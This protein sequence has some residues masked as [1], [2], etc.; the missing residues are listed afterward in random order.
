VY[1]GVTGGAE[2]LHEVAE[3]IHSG[4]PEDWAKAA[5]AIA[6]SYGMVKG[7]SHTLA[8]KAFQ[9]R[10]EPLE[11]REAMRAEISTK[12]PTTTD[13][14]RIALKHKVPATDV[15]HWSTQPLSEIEMAQR[16]AAD[17][18]ETVR[19]S[20]MDAAK[21]DKRKP[22]KTEQ[23]TLFSLNSKA[24][25]LKEVGDA[26]L[27]TRVKAVDN[28]PAPKGRTGS[29]EWYESLYKH[30]WTKEVAKALEIPKNLLMKESA[31]I[32][33][34]RDVWVAQRNLDTHRMVVD[35]AN[36]VP[37]EDRAVDKLGWVIQDTATPEEV[38]LSPEARAIIPVFQEA[39]RMQ[40]KLQYGQYGDD[41][42]LQD[43]TTYLTQEWD[44]GGGA[45]KGKVERVARK[46]M[47]DRNL[48]KKVISSY[49][50]GMEDGIMVDGERIFLKPKYN[51]V[52]Q[53][54]KAHADRVTQIL[55]NRRMANALRDMGAIISEPEYNRLRPGHFAKVV[56]QQ[57]NAA[58]VPYA[59]PKAVDF[60]EWKQMKDAHALYRAAYTDTPMRLAP[61]GK[62]GGGFKYAPVRVHPDYYDAVNAVFGEGYNN[63]V[64]NALDTYRALGKVTTLGFSLF[65]NFSL[66]ASAL[67]TWSTKASP[68]T[69][70]GKTFFLHPEYR[71]GLKSGLF[72]V[73][74]R[75][76]DLPPVLRYND[77]LTADA[78]GEG[79]LK[80]DS[81]DREK[82]VYAKVQEL[83]NSRNVAAKAMGVALKPLAAG[84]KILDR[85]TFDFYQQ[86]LMLETYEM[87]KSQELP[88]LG[89]DASPAKIREVKRAIGDHVNNQFGA[90]SS[91]RLLMSPKVRQSLNFAFL[92]PNWTIS[93]LRTIT[94]GYETEAGMRLTNDYVRGSVISW[95]LGAQLMNM[96]TTAWYSRNDKDGMKPRLTWDN[97]GLE[98]ATGPALPGATG[99]MSEN[100][101]YIYAGKN[102]DG[103]D[104]YY[105]P[106]KGT[107]GEPL[108]WL[109]DPWATF[110]GKVSLPVRML[111]TQATDSAPGSG[112]QEIR[113]QD[114]LED[115]IVQHV[116]S[117]VKDSGVPIVGERLL[118]SGA[119][120]LFPKAIDAPT[121]S[122]SVSVG[123]FP[124]G[125]PTRKAVSA[126]R[127]YDAY[128]AAK[129]EGD[130]NRAADILAFAASQGIKTS[131]MRSKYKSDKRTREK[132]AAK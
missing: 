130:G 87:L 56:E 40:D 104:R 9:F 74:G 81:Q 20:V 111:F 3:A 15:A 67:A 117:F 10:A 38:G 122:E 98:V 54:Y 35:W 61:Q 100:G 124:I 53:I 129:D 17:K 99:K 94:A 106:D 123:G 23:A 103:S 49:R 48:R 5:K 78:L 27:E 62:E 127:A 12:S 113:P 45:G 79:G 50:S 91:E 70:L 68:L 108:R 121:Q 101:L 1:L 77:V 25:M 42:K 114:R 110:W 57:Q 11:S 63:P 33:R 96:A 4:S 36:K 52:F 31:D 84:L 72:E 89:P 119:H 66:T 64:F 59:T 37:L 69:T 75:K 46:M 18:F 2:G 21:K 39:T 132:R 13:L 83:A 65:H 14:A 16:K 112:F 29:R 86:G 73:I 102:S 58:G 105:V 34:S 93:K 55:A 97:P 6:S 24:K 85:A 60:T 125:L 19:K 41:L 120:R 44:F 43:W 28:I 107:I 118:Q 90:I 126:T 47:N 92:A 115:R 51:D 8:S 116:A 71:R 82:M 88:K 30:A 131:A 7:G 26:A 109:N 128:R 22:T 80:L 32:V 95:F 76:G